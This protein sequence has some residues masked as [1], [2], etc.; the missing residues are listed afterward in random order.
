MLVRLHVPL[1]CSHGA[2]HHR[3]RDVCTK[4]QS[5][6]PRLVGLT[7]GPE[8]LEMLFITSG[9]KFITSPRVQRLSVCPSPIA[10]EG[11]IPFFVDDD[12]V[13]RQRGCDG[14]KY[15]FQEIGD[16]AR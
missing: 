4:H 15:G 14:G 6:S 5:K 9:T 16:E 8:P 10:L 7:K 13:K 2:F 12:E 1:Q 3:S 11:K